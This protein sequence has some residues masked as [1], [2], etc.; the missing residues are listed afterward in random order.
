[1]SALGR[2]GA[3]LLAL[4]VLL[5][6]L[7]PVIAAQPPDEASGSPYES[8][9]A[10]HPLGTDDVGQDLFAQLLHGARISL[11]VGL[12]TALVAVGIGL[13]VALLAGYLRGRVE[14]VLMRLVDMALAFP[15]LVLVI[16]LAAFLGRGLL[17][18]VVVIGAVIWAMPARIL[19]S[20]VIKVRELHHVVAARAMGASTARVIGRHVLPRL[21]PLAVAQF[22]RTAN[23]AIFIEASL[24]FLGLGDPSRVS[25]GTMLFFANARGAFLTEAWLWWVVPPGLALT[26]TLVGLAFLGYAIEERSDPRLARLAGRRARRRRRAAAGVRG[27][28]QPEPGVHGPAPAE[29]GALGQAPNGSRAGRRPGHA[30]ADG[31]AGAGPRSDGAVLEVRDLSVDYET[32]AGA[33]RAVDGVSL[34]VRRGQVVGLVGESGSGKS[35]LAMTLLGLVPPPGRVREGTVV[36]GGRDLRRLRRSQ[37]PLVRGRQIALVPQSAM[38]SLNPAYAVRR[39]VAETAALTRPDPRAAARRAAELLELVGIPATRHGSF[40]HEL[41]GGMRQRVAIAMAIAN[42]PD[43]LIADEPV[44]GLDVVTQAR[45][46]ELLTGLRRE[47][48]LSMLLVSHDLRLVARVADELHVM[49]CGRIVEAGPAAQL[50]SAPIHPYTRALLAAVPSVRGARRQLASIPG[51]PADPLRPPR[52]CNF[53]PRCPVAVDAC[54]A[55]DPP[56]YEPAPGR[57]CACVHLGPR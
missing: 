25:W 31:S 43:V 41:S 15:F 46:L 26:A 57:R 54:G 45:I 24:A 11:A 28:R 44:T 56:L 19:R 38:N 20:Q 29:A 21:A 37:L 53:K 42:E 32:P 10:G 7:A 34:A 18:T 4:I 40:P 3:G 30:G 51:D 55:G 48:D 39:Q 2:I 52:G 8:P 47:L 1:M 22:V 36:L 9:S 16:V 12:L 50:G 49:Y 14:T 23:I 13:A 35:T 5:A 27:R 33:A 6:A 17:T